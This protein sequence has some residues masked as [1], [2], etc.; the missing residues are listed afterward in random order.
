MK[1][2]Y[3]RCFIGLLL[4]AV[5]VQVSPEAA[6]SPNSGLKMTQRCSIE[7]QLLVKKIVPL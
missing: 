6:H 3:I 7:K 4:I 1:I 2:E 5:I